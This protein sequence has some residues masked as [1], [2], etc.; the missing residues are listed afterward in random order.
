MIKVSAERE[1]EITIGVSWRERLT[2]IIARHNKILIVAPQIIVDLYQLHSITSERVSL[3]IS[4]EAEEQKSILQ[5]SELIDLCGDIGLTRSDAVVA[6]GG[7]ATS[8]L[9]GFV[10]ASWLRGVSWYA[11]PTS[12]AAM[13]DA[14]IGGKTGINTR[15]GKNLVGAFFSPAEVIIDLAFL[16]SLSDRDFS[17]GL[18]EIIKTAF[19]GP[20]RI[21]E[22]L[23]SCS[24]LSEVRNQ[25]L[26]II[27]L[28]AQYKAKVVSGD[29][30]EGRE[31]EV[32]N[33]GHTL[34]HAIEKFES[35]SLRHGEAVAIGLV[36]AAELSHLCC[37]LSMS[38]V[39][40]HRSLLSRFA[41]P[42][43]FSPSALPQLLEYM[44]GDKKSR[45]AQM[46]FIGISQPGQPAWLEQ[47]TID[48]I[49]SAY[50]KI[51]P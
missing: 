30:R 4:R 7:G 36:F 28:T 26:E 42:T 45:G 14:A 38:E 10:A 22:I 41:L 1:Y 50:E 18:A 39:D 25:L 33:Y 29:F 40:R 51:A 8:D 46:R 44:Q 43:T 15:H 21:L 13:V 16:E 24:D 34:A 49:T 31:R 5:W 35:Y 32:L 20:V 37:G 47:V 48:Q 12:L 6:I 19:I 17:A 27:T 11:L 23:E 2:E 9:A 3:A